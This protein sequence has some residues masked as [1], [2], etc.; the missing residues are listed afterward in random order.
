MSLFLSSFG[1]MLF[2][3]DEGFL[4]FGFSFS[5]LSGFSF[6][7]SCF[8]SFSGVESSPDFSFGVLL[9]MTRLEGEEFLL[10][11]LGFLLSS[12]WSE[13]SRDLLLSSFLSEGSRE[14]EGLGD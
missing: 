6:G 8:V 7:F 10:G 3:D 2:E 5:P 9:L 14:V 12:F 1:D 11:I 13:E 4:T